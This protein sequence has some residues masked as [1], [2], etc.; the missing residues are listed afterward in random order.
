MY[1]LVGLLLV[2]FA[3]A[4][5]VY[6]HKTTAQHIAAIF[7]QNKTEK[8]MSNFEFDDDLEPDGLPIEQAWAEIEKLK[9]YDDNE[10]SITMSG[11]IKFYD[12]WNEKGVKDQQKFIF[13]QAGNYQILTIDSFDRV[14]IDDKMMLIDH[15]QKIIEIQNIKKQDSIATTLKTM[16]KKGLK[17]MLSKN[18]VTAKI[19]LEGDLKV[20]RIYP[21][22]D[23][24]INT[25]SIYYNPTTYELKKY[26]LSYNNFPLENESVSGEMEDSLV[27]AQQNIDESKIKETAD[28]PD[29][30]SALTEYVIEF[31][32]EKQQKK[33]GFNFTNNKLFSLNNAN[34]VKFKSY[35]KDYEKSEF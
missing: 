34:E 5:P 24:A 26:T 16:D 6:H 17:N 13:Q 30:T 25:Y 14:Q 3:F 31:V 8:E 15:P 23:D 19:E 7:T 12:N 9:L 10:D 33:C 32:I 27:L 22:N 21:G 2:G 20:L 11:T 35:L 29:F 18:G 28:D 1:A 4:V